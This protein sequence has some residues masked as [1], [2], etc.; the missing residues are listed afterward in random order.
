MNKYI[1][2]SMDNL[3]GL[4]LLSTPIEDHSSDKHNQVNLKALSKRQWVTYII[5][6]A[7]KAGFASLAHAFIV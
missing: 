1:D 6:T 3:M 2:E 7:H 5:D 4:E